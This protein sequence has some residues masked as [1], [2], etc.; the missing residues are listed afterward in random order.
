[1]NL[2]GGEISYLLQ[3]HVVGEK[4]VEYPGGFDLGGRVLLRLHDLG[5]HD[6]HAVFQVVQLVVQLRQAA[7]PFAHREVLELANREKG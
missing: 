2:D 6:E 3:P 5:T 4:L 1:M 7:T